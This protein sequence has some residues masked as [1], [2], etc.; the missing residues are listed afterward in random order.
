M[1]KHN[2]PHSKY[3]AIQYGGWVKIVIWFGPSHKPRGL[4]AIERMIG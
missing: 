3:A 4:A 2:V 1:N